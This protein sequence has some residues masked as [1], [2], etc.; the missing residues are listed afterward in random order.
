MEGCS[1]AVSP[2]EGVF[3]SIA[4]PDIQLGKPVLV[5]G[6][7]EGTVGVRGAP[8]AVGAASASRVANGMAGEAVGRPRGAAGADPG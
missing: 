1:E 7:E 4:A 2:A 6:E 8:P 3:V 5:G